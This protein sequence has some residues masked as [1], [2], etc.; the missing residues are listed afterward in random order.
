MK[1]NRSREIRDI[2]QG[3]AFGKSPFVNNLKGFTARSFATFGT[4]HEQ[5][6]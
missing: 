5:Y 4:L 3:A 6:Q 2:I 1:L